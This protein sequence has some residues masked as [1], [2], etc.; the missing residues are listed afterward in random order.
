MKP[1]EQSFPRPVCNI[2]F[3]DMES[4]EKIFEVDELSIVAFATPETRLD[5][6]FFPLTQL[7]DQ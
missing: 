7:K 4:L 1:V 2:A 3:G 6:D 5:D